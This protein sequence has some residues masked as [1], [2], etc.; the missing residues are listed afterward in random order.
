MSKPRAEAEHDS[1][2]HETEKMSRILGSS[3][4][5]LAESSEH[6]DYAKYGYHHV[7]LA[8]IESI[9][10]ITRHFFD[11]GYLLEMVTCQ[12]RRDDAGT[13]R[14]VYTFNHLAHLDRHLV[15][16]D[17]AADAE[18]P[19]ITSLYQAADW[20]EREVYDMYGVRFSGH[21]NLKRI[22]LPEDADFYALRKDFGRIEDAPQES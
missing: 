11:A 5:E 14:L 15:H 18:A 21:P 1:D 3:V 4:A 9:P 7:Y 10:E 20:F 2:E 17:V 8:N 22:L 6:A 16:A 12:D 19:S 13:M